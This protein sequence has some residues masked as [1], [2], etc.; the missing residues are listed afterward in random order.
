MCGTCG[1]GQSTSNHHHQH[2]EQ[3]IKIEQNI[4]SVNNQY[5]QQNRK[6]CDEHNI[7]PINL[8]SS[9]GSG[10][11]TLLT[12]TLQQ[13]KPHYSLAVIE[14]DQQTDVDAQ[15]I[16][17]TGVD[18]IQI[19][20]GKSCHLE[21][22]QVGHAI[23][24]LTFKDGIL[25]I[26]NVGNLVCP[27]LFDL[28]E[29]HKVVILSVTEGDNKPLKYPHMFQAASL[30]LINKIDLL[31]YVDFDVDKCIDYAKQVNPDI[32]SLTLSAT[33]GE[34]MASWYTWLKQHATASSC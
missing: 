29:A 16:A 18:V 4:M 12:Q 1:C 20:T 24:D 30:M 19:N 33:Q 13:L 2:D 27:S 31:P 28:G 6:Y 22:H 8:V 9:P 32:Q 5:A 7:F 15:Q 17:T 21:A 10:K 23:Q 34:G 25:F 14:G 26:E 3:L 11:T